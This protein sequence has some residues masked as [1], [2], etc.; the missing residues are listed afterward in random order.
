MFKCIQF[1]YLHLQLLLAWIYWIILMLCHFNS[2][3]GHFLPSL[4]PVPVCHEYWSCILFASSPF[5]FFVLICL[6]VGVTCASC[7]MTP[8]SSTDLWEKNAMED[9]LCGNA[10]EV[11]FFLHWSRGWRLKNKK[12]LQKQ[13]VAE[14]GRPQ[15]NYMFC[16]KLP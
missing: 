4:E 8:P 13:V 6:W 9:L 7:H 11:W 3:T 5:F 10:A 12:R 15:S 16:S 14:S 1:A 2:S